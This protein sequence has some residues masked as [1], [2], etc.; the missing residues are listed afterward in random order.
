[1]F[2]QRTKAMQFWADLI[3]KR[4]EG[5]VNG[6]VYPGA[7]LT[8]IQDAD[9]A[10]QEGIVDVAFFASSY[11]CPRHPILRVFEVSGAF[12]PDADLLLVVDRAIRPI[13]D[14]SLARSNIKYLFP[15][16]EGESAVNVIKERGPIRK[17]EDW[18][19]L[20]IR[21][22]GRWVGKMIESLGAVPVV[23][24]TGELPLAL[25]RKTVDGGYSS[26]A[27]DLAFKLYEVAPN[28]TQFPDSALWAFAGMNLEKFNSLS[29][30]DQEILMQACDEASVYSGRAGLRLRDLYFEKTKEAGIKH[31][32]LS[33]E[34][35]KLLLEKE[36]QFID[37]LEKDASP[38]ELELLKVLKRFRMYYGKL[39]Y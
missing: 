8:K 17:L 5:R 23:I 37:S 19:G 32:Y 33:E 1:V 22:Y 28:V 25:Q 2:D 30:D 7:S 15:T 10:T 31:N 11:A 34:Q 4:T 35:L 14:K 9:I 16:Y 29:P 3:E 6:K 21:V 36:W 24:P 18:K 39:K 26:W 12:P 13:L 20:K 38:E 27:I